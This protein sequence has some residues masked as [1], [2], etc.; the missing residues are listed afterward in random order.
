MKKVFIL[1]VWGILLSFS[2]HGQGIRENHIIDLSMAYGKDVQN[3]SLE[4][5]HRWGILWKKRIK[6]GY[7]LRFNNVFGQGTSLVNAFQAMGNEP[8]RDTL[9]VRNTEFHTLN[10]SICAE[11]SFLKWLDAGVNIDIFGFSFGP[12]RTATYYSESYGTPVSFQP[13]RPEV[14]NVF[15]FG[16]KDRGSLNSQ[17]FLRFWLPHDISLRAGFS[18]LHLYYRSDNVLNFQNDRFF[19]DPKMGF[20]SIAWSPGRSAWI[21]GKK[22]R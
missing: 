17:F 4:W 2:L 14:L 5:S 3:Y 19:I 22:E 10:I 18:I 16:R 1:V 9:L 7:G 13:V 11:V 12:Q 20:I 8:P 6:L 21:S 15:L